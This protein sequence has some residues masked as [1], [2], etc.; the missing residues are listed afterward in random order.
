MRARGKWSNDRE[1]SRN[2]PAPCCRVSSYC[3]DPVQ[4]SW[5][6]GGEYDV[7]NVDEQEGRDSLSVLLA[8]SPQTRLWRPVESETLGTRPLL[9]LFLSLSPLLCSLY[10]SLC[11]SFTVFPYFGPR[12]AHSLFALRHRVTNI[13]ICHRKDRLA[14][15]TSYFRTNA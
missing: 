10:F 11:F 15:S 2:Q 14:S 6:K 5:S 1:V 13:R 9:S 7:A 8:F 4:T 3:T 12:R